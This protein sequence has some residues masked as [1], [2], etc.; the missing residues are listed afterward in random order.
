MNKKKSAVK[1]IYLFRKSVG[2]CLEFTSFCVIGEGKM[3]VL[4]VIWCLFIIA[5]QSVAVKLNYPRVLLPIFDKLSINFTLEVI[6]GGCFKW[7]DILTA[8]NLE[9]AFYFFLFESTYS[10]MIANG[11]EIMSNGI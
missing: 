1:R 8:H 2:K 5:Q 10:K 9:V 11:C 6:E 4:T 3:R 7:Y